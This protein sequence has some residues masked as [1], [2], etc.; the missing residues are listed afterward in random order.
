MADE[1]GLGLEVNK[2][3]RNEGKVAFWTERKGGTEA[4]TSLNR[5]K[6]QGNRDE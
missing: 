1:E 3:G 4:A 5:R 6:G 2:E